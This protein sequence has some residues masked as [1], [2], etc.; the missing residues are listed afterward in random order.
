MKV[1]F[2]YKN[3]QIPEENSPGM[4]VSLL[5]AIFKNIFSLD[6]KKH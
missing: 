2:P 1:Y 5:M 3:S 4:M 6:T